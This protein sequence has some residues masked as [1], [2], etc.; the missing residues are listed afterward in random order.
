ME[1]WQSPESR[2][3]SGSDIIAAK[4]WV[5]RRPKGAAEPTS[6][7]LDFIRASEE[8]E[9]ARLTAQR[10]QLAEIAAAQEERQKAL[11]AAEQALDR[12]IRLKRGQAWV[13]AIVPWHL[14]QWDG[15]P[16]A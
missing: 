5:A 3:L 2:L 10:K 4:T 9:D 14:G 11:I 1:R 8:G 16:T 13:A 7:H 12:T 6:L 15:G